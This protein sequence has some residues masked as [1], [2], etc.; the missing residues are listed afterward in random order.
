MILERATT[1]WYWYHR[2]H[3]NREM[4]EECGYR[5][6]ENQLHQLQIGR[7]EMVPTGERTK[8]PTGRP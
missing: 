2:L 1:G 7:T 8:N 6:R 3:T 4:V 5:N